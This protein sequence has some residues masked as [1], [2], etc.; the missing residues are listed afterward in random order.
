[1]IFDPP[2]ENTYD[3]PR[4]ETDAAVIAKLLSQDWTQRPT[5]PAFDPTKQAAPEWVN[6]AW[7]VDDLSVTQQAQYA[8][9]AAVAK[10]YTVQPEGFILALDDNARNLFNQGL[11]LVQLLLSTGASK[12]TDAFS[13][14]DSSGVTHLITMQRYL[15]IMAAY[16]VYYYGLWKAAP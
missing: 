3:G 13:I 12:P 1:M 4:S 11:A 14:A 15:E 7:V 16:G 2:K 9:D 5:A 6:G 8:Y 10:G